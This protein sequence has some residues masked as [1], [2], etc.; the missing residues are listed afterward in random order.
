MSQQTVAEPVP[1]RPVEVREAF[2]SLLERDMLGPEEELEPGTSRA[3]RYLLGRLVPRRP[4]VEPPQDDPDDEFVGAE[5]TDREVTSGAEDISDVEPEATTRFGSMA[6]SSLGL[7][8]MVPTD[9]DAVT[10]KAS[11]GRYERVPSQSH[12]T[13]QGR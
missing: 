10:V 12:Q 5:L 11:W 4:D 3:E 1:A 6:A 2:E 8:F 7:S 13:P 9:V